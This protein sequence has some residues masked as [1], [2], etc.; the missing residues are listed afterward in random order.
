MSISIDGFFEWLYSLSIWDLV[1]ILLFP[2][3]VDFSRTFG[4][5]IFLLLHHMKERKKRQRRQ[6][7]H[8][9]F[10]ISL[11]IPAHNEES[12]IRRSLEAAID[13]SYQNK[14]II[15]ID[16]G[17]TDNTYKIAYEFAQK[18]LI[19]LIRREQSSGSKAGALNSGAAYATGDI[20]I[21]VDADTLIERKAFDEISKY[22]EDKKVMAV[23]GNVRILSGDDGVKNI[24]TKL[25]AY[26]YL[27]SMEMG[28]RYN[29]ILNSLLIVSGAFG[30]FRKDLFSG[31]GMY[32]KDTLTEDFDLTVKVRKS[33]AK[34]G[35]ATESIGWTFCPNNWKAWR[36]QRMRWTQG[37]LKTLLKHKDITWT[38]GYRF[39][40]IMSIYDMWFMDIVLLV[41]R[42]VWIPFMILYFTTTWFYTMTFLAMIYVAS[43]AFVIV[44][45]GIL[46]PRKQDLRFV[47]LA[48]V[49]VFFYRPLYA[50]I[51][52]AACLKYF[53]GKDVKW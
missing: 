42:F 33:G 40:L 7:L 51:R 24:L 49:M 29:A 38:S 19:K 3:I 31:V 39:V 15:V 21:S 27:V 30:S 52:F 20:I 22:F 10:K 17:S 2:V 4:K 5:S 13:S 8:P 41:A 47:Y 28:R 34:L 12:N 14:E 50:I 46:S 25:Q 1:L 37:Q 16:D 26:E 9:N 36:R 48:P 11:L 6:S 44:S 32:D 35:F 43:E 53:F 23:S 18:K 45:A